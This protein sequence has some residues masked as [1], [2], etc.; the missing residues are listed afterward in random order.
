MSRAATCRPDRA[1]SGRGRGKCR[2]CC[3]A[4]RPPT[5]KFPSPPP[6]DR[7]ELFKRIRRGNRERERDREAA[8][9]L[10]ADVADSLRSRAARRWVNGED[11]LEWARELREA[12]APLRGDR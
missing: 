1:A 8:L 6:L 12:L 5:T 2:C 10:I 3:G 9:E 4:A 7:D 11:L